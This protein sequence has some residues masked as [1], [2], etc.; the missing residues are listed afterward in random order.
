[1]PF[2][3]RAATTYPFF[4]TALWGV[5]SAD[6][7]DARGVVG[8]SSSPEGYGVFGEATAETGDSFGVAGHAVSPDGIGVYGLHD[9][10]SGTAP[11][12]HGVTHSN[13][14]YATGVLGEVFPEA[15]AGGITYG[16]KGT[17]MTGDGVG[18]FGN[19]AAVGVRGQ[20]LTPDGVGVRGVHFA[21]TGDAPGV[22][23]TTNSTTDYAVGVK[24]EAT[25]TSSDALGIGVHGISHAGEGVG[26]YGHAAN[27]VSGTT[28]Y[29]GYFVSDS[30]SGWGV[31]GVAS[32]ANAFAGFFI[33]RGYFSGDV[34]IGTST[35]DARLDVAGTA[36]CDVLQIDSGADLSENFAVAGDP[37]PGMVVVID[38]DR[39]GGL[40][41]SDRAYD[42][43]V[44]GIISGAGGVQ[45]GMLMSQAGS[46]ADG[47]YPVALTGR[48]Y[49]RCDASTG[50]IEPGDMLT[51]SDTPGHAM[52]VSDYARA[53]GAIIGKSMT[54]LK[55][56]ETGL[57][58]VLVNLQ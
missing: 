11:G 6:T 12:V 42:R 53:Q 29:G 10:L 49:C 7:G 25:T 38:S 14:D 2:A 22:H 20:S 30:E 27:T 18:V 15:G 36:R 3:V 40:C 1:V 37:Q 55:Q 32:G 50:T 9:Y 31:T 57:V 33:G 26:V 41:V 43:R 39:P 13:Q 4:G 51:T 16:V 24:G 45:T 44:A 56:G 8:T 21:S 23:G 47:D 28:T 34:G 17:S 54:S 5:A 48:V 35:P 46:V 58:L 19:G 52:K